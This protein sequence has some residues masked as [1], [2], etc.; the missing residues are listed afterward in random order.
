MR[1][2]IL[3][4]ILSTLVIGGIFFIRV[5]IKTKP[6]VSSQQSE[7]MKRILSECSPLGSPL[8]PKVK[9]CEQKIRSKE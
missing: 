4:I 8:D 1:A 2:K 7:L 9:E 6:E 5:L 3:L